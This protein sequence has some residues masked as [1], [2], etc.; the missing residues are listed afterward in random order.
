MACALIGR[1]QSQ[2]SLTLIRIVTED[3]Q[4]FDSGFLVPSLTA[5]KFGKDVR[6]GGFV[7][8]PRRKEKTCPTLPDE[9]GKGRHR[10]GDNPKNSPGEEKH[11][12]N[13]MKRGM[14][15]H[16]QTSRIATQNKKGATNLNCTEQPPKDHPSLFH[17]E[18][19]LSHQLPG[20]HFNHFSTFQLSSGDLLP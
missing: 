12:R 9:G 4:V 6:E 15:T 20:F 18:K 5:V 17:R 11:A 7:E 19:S 14:R 8:S 2:I 10:L 1:D 3:F 16:F 13:H